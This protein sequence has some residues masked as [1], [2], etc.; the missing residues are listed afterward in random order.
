MAEREVNR[1]RILENNQVKYSRALEIQIAEIRDERERI[2][3]FKA[4]P[5]MA[6]VPDGFAIEFMKLQTDN[7]LMTTE[8]NEMRLQAA[9]YMDLYRQERYKPRQKAR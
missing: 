6:T 3:K 7:R 9:K 2:E 5:G 1:W 4:Q 8:L